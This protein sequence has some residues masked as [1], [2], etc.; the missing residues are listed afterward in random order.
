M[1]VWRTLDMGPKNT[2]TYLE[3]E[4]GVWKTPDMGPKSIKYGSEKRIIWGRKIWGRISRCRWCISMDDE[5]RGVRLNWRGEIMTGLHA[6]IYVGHAVG[7]NTAAAEKK[8]VVVLLRSTRAPSRKR[9]YKDS[10][11]TNNSTRRF[12]LRSHFLSQ[13]SG[14]SSSFVPHF[15]LFGTPGSP[16]IGQCP[17]ILDH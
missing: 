1:W 2:T 8:K 14:S 6:N 16:I 17:L 3:H 7:V 9:A 4:I 13:H 11:V 12:T 10:D 15:F 5:T